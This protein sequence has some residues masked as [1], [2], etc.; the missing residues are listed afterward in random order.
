MGIFCQ[1][2]AEA[3]ADVEAEIGEI[4]KIAKVDNAVKMPI[5]AVKSR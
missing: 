3:E 2:E 5:I 1:A 4:G